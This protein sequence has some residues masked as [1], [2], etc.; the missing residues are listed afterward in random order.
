MTGPPNV[1]AVTGASGYIGARLLQQLEEESLDK[2]VA[3]DTRPPPYPIHNIAVYRHDVERPIVDIL[4]QWSVSTLV[5]LAFDGKRGSS[6]RDIGDIQQANLR[7]LNAVIG[8]CVQARVSHL[9]YLSSHT[10]YGARPNNPVPITE[11]SPLSPIPVSP[12][13]YTKT[14]SEQVLAA[15]GERHPQIRVTI[16]RPCSVLGPSASNDLSRVF[17]HPGYLEIWGRNPPL[18]FLHEDDLAR[19]ITVLIQR[20][21]AGIFNV[22]GEGVAFHREVGEIVHRKPLSL[23][24]FLAGPLVEFTWQLGLQNGTTRGELNL[25]RFPVLLSTAKLEA[26]TGYHPRYTSLESVTAFANTVLV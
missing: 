20:G 10:V 9:I 23:P 22:A 1:V 16:L 13:G 4:R 12:F 17:L 5:H 18:Q 21:L 15:F 14:L 25:S 6:R 2:L 8:S 26:A 24:T 19:I 11:R 7:A 3:F